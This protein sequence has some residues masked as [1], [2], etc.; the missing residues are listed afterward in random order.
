MA[1]VVEEVN[2]AEE[3]V[4]FSIFSFTRD[5]LREALIGRASAYAAYTWPMII[6]SER[7]NIRLAIKE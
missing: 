5:D 7:K 6:R 1:E 3:S 2:A 4:Y